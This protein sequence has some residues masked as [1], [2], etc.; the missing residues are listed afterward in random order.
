MRTLPRLP[1]A[2]VGLAGCNHHENASP[3]A[4]SAPAAETPPTG[5]APAV[6]SAG[7]SMRY[8]CDDGSSVEILAAGGAR[9]T[10]SDGRVVQLPAVPGSS[11]PAFAAE[12]LSFAIGSNGGQ[13][14]QDEGGQRN[15]SAR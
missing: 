10:L 1:V 11:P 9:A 6:A 8:R 7:V 4:A 5:T 2:L 12:A 15:C 13:L 14:S 3:P